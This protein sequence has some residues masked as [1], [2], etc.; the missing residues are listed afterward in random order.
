MTKK[1]IVIIA[2]L[3]AAVAARA[4]DF[5]VA[6]A[7]GQYV[8]YSIIPGTTTVKAVNPNWSSHAEPMGFLVLPATVEH[9]GVTYQLKAVDAEAFRGCSSLTGVSLPEGVTS[10]GRMAFAFCSSLDSIVLP[11]TLTV[12]GTQAFTGTAYFSNNAHLNADGLM[13]VGPFIIAART[14]INGAITVP[15]GILGLGNMAFYNCNQMP[16]V[17]LPTTLTFIGENAFGSCLSLDTVKLL[18]ATPPTLE[19]NSF[20]DVPHPVAAVPCEAGANYQTATY[21]SALTIV[22]MCD[23]GSSEP[24]TPPS[25]VGERPDIPSFPEE[26][27]PAPDIHEPTYHP[28][29]GIAD[30]EA[31]NRFAATAVEGGLLIVLPDGESCTVRDVLGH[32]VAT[33]QHTGFVPL[34]SAGIYLVVCPALN[35]TI[36]VIYNR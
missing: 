15:E 3:L 24:V 1:G 5:R 31:A 10:L 16:Q 25:H 36:K 21:W 32:T 9:N 30:I 26:P 14:N 4:F 23:T 22:E 20:Q 28:T 19:V 7:A 18:T 8:Y 29:V 6:T 17:T 11:S 12:I 27:Y 13:I 35:K 2:M 33:L 34:R